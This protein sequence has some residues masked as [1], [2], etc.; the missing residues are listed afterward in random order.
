MIYKILF[1][2]FLPVLAFSQASNELQQK[3]ID[4]L[5]AGNDIAL[6]EMYLDQAGLYSEGGLFTNQ[7]KKAEILKRIKNE[8]GPFEGYAQVFQTKGNQGHLMTLGYLRGGEKVY[9]TIIAWRKVKGEYKKEF[10]SIAYL[11]SSDI[12]LPSEELDLMRREWE[13]HSNNHD[14]KTLIEKVYSPQSHYFNQGRID[15]GREI[16]IKRYNYMTMD[17]WTIRLEKA[18]LIPVSDNQVWEIGKYY[19]TGEGQYLLIWE[20]QSDGEWQIALDFNF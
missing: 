3:W 4:Y 19:S 2:L 9:A 13:K 20:K 1:F 14:P 7:K 10:E 12:V 5:N 17:S 11:T 16:I 18:G 15:Q 6:Q 8:F